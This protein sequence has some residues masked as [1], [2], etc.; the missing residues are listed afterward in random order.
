VSNATLFAVLNVVVSVRPSFLERTFALRY[1]ISTIQSISTT[2][3][4]NQVVFLMTILFFQR[5][6]VLFLQKTAFSTEISASLWISYRV[7]HI[8]FYRIQNCRTEHFHWRYF[9]EGNED[10]REQEQAKNVKS[11]LREPLIKIMVIMSL[12]RI[13]RVRI[14]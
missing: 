10:I 6:N 3:A 14:K 13:I 5:L 7:Y 9:K 4:R 11:F 1:L 12:I 2:K 8:F